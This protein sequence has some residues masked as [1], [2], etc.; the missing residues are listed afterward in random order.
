MTLKPVHA[1]ARE[2]KRRH[3][4]GEDGVAEV[5]ASEER[6]EQARGAVERAKA[7][8]GRHQTSRPILFP[9]RASTASQPLAVFLVLPHQPRRRK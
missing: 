1:T 6:L 8:L 7:Q 9:T 3:Q 2:A 4:A 5:H